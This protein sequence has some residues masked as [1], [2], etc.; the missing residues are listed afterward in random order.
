[1]KERKITDSNCNLF[2]PNHF[3]KKRRLTTMA[4]FEANPFV[5][6]EERQ[7]QSNNNRVHS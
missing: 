7:T 5:F 4:H 2:H 3:R 1:M 6:I